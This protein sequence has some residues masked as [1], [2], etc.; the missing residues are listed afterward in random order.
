M[1]VSAAKNPRADRAPRL[2]AGPSGDRAA[3]G[4]GER[5]FFHRRELARV[6]RPDRTR[7]IPCTVHAVTGQPPAGT[8]SPRPRPHTTGQCVTHGRDQRVRPGLR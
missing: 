5:L 3:D 8:D 2:L 4:G 1:S 7:A 6:P